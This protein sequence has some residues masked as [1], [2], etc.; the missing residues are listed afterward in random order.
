MCLLNWSHDAGRRAEFR[1]Q[2]FARR[3]PPDEGHHCD[4]PVFP[5]PVDGDDWEL[6][7]SEQRGTQVT[8]AHVVEAHTMYTIPNERLISTLTRGHNVALQVN[9]WFS[10]SWI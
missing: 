1:T 6:G 4:V 9:G 10:V 3:L 8:F 7:E 2:L 5:L